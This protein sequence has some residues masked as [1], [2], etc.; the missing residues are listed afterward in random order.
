MDTKK[1]P[2]CG[3]SKSFEDFCKDKANKDGLKCYCKTC[4]VKLVREWRKAN[5]EHNKKWNQNN[6]N[7]I[8]EYNKK[9]NN[10]KPWEREFADAVNNAVKRGRMIKSEFCI[11]RGCENA[12]TVA[13]HPIYWKGYEYFVLWLCRSCHIE[14]HSKYEPTLPYEDKRQPTLF[15]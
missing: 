6:K 13:H 8:A 12:A 14:W 2:K 5:P 10:E 7:K 4:N 9:R 1:C 11:R 15:D 3:E